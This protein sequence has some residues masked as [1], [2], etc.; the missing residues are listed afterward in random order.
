[1]RTPLTLIALTISLFAAIVAPA[2]AL[3]PDALTLPQ[4]R[5]QIRVA[6]ENWAGLIDGRAHIGR[7]ERP[8][9]ALVR[10][11][12][13][14]KSARTRCDMEVTVRRTRSYDSLRARGVRCSNA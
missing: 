3:K 4:A 13:V 2:A 10:C 12:V 11:G 14:I 6:T 8:D 1:M 7:C 5:Q 9:R